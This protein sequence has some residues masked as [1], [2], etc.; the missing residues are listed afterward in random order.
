MALTLAEGLV[1][2]L[3]GYIEE[4]LPAK[5]AAID[6]EYNDG[7]ILEIPIDTYTGI[8]SLDTIPA[9][10]ALYIVSPSE[11]FRVMMGAAGGDS[12][13]QVLVGIVVVD[14][15]SETLQRR[16][17]RYG[18][19]LKAL[20]LDAIAASDLNDWVLSTDEIWHTDFVM[21][22]VMEM[23]SNSYEGRV[24]LAM[25]ALKMETA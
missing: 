11:D 24:T 6:A 19:A 12:M 20:M 25:R 4:Y 1:V 5:L 18:R 15:N 3:Q 14:A 22:D 2:S 13:P 21:S 8:K 7:I 17:Y 16:V 9:Y 10:P 23:E